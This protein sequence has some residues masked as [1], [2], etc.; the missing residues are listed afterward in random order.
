LNLLLNLDQKKESKFLNHL[1]DVNQDSVKR[2]KKLADNDKMA[3]SL[4]SIAQ[5]Q[6]DILKKIKEN[7]EKDEPHL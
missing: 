1:I 4:Q 6:A 3:K 7:E 2:Y 5:G